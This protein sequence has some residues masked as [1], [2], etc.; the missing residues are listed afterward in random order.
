MQIGHEDIVDK[1][2]NQKWESRIDAEAAAYWYIKKYY[3]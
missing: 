1:D 3:V 2:G